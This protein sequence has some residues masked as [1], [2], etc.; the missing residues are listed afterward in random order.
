MATKP[1]TKSKSKTS[2]SSQLT[3]FK[4]QW[5]MAL[6]LVAV[7]AIIGVVIVRFSYASGSGGNC[8]FYSGHCQYHTDDISRYQVPGAV[9][10][11]GC[12]PFK[13][14]YSDP[15]YKCARYEQN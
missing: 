14:V 8:I 9:K 6:I 5:W 12:A 7:V 15:P 4:F 11:Y 3:Q 13:Y 10:G 2:K 1:K